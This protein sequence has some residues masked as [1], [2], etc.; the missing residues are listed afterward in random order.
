M[1]I[2]HKHL[3]VPGICFLF[4][5]SGIVK[6]QN[7]DS[8]SSSIALAF[9]I[10][11]F[12]GFGSYVLLRKRVAREGA[13]LLPWKPDGP[14]WGAKGSVQ[15][16]VNSVIDGLAGGFGMTIHEAFV[17]DHPFGWQAAP[18][19][20]FTIGS[21]LGIRIFMRHGNRPRIPAQEVN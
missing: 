5:A 19:I 14:I 2:H 9:L 13:A 4:G 20:G 8:V 16:E 3:I 7:S 12:A 11:P 1:K 15:I 18:I 17:S 10:A 6:L 21:L